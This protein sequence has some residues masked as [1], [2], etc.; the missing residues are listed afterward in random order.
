MRIFPLIL[1]GNKVNG[2]PIPKNRARETLGFWP[3]GPV[4]MLHRP[5]RAGKIGKGPRRAR[6][7]E[8]YAPQGPK[9]GK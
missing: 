4:K 2:R 6:K 7:N 9:N 3:A 5:R 1:K 8:K